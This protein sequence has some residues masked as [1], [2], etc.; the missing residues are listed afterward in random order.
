MNRKHLRQS[1]M[2]VVELM[3]VVIILAMILAVVGFGLRS[4]LFAPEV[5]ANASEE[6]H[7]WVHEMYPEVPADQVHIVCQG[8]DTDGNGYVTCSARVGE[9]HLSLECY[10][11]VAVNPGENTCREISLLRAGPGSR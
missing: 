4:C 3:I 6:A 1:G 9:E 11:Y 7:T 5:R 8:T 2:T 10:A